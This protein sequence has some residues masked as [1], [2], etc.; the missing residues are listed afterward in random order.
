MNSRVGKRLFVPAILVLQ[1][2]EFISIESKKNWLHAEAS[3]EIL[4]DRNKDRC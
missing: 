4:F 1:Q 3:L 2:G